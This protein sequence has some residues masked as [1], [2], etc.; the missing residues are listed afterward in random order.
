MYCLKLIWGAGIVFCLL[1]VRPLCSAR[2]EDAGP[3]ASSPGQEPVIQVPAQT[4]RGVSQADLQALFNQMVAAAQMRVP[5]PATRFI[6]V[7]VTA[8]NAGGS[9]CSFPLNVLSGLQGST[10]RSEDFRAASS[11]DQ[12][13]ATSP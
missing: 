9:L 7:P 13:E 3:G 6:P 10:V 8:S 4:Q 11:R 1:S 12:V 2:P 5:I